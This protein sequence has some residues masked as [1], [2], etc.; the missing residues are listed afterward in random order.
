MRKVHEG[1]YDAIVLAHAGLTRIGLAG[2]ITQVLTEEE[3]LPAPGQGC[4]GLELR[5][6][7]ETLLKFLETIKDASSDAAAR[8]ERAFLSGL[9]G[10]CL[11][12]VGALAT[13]QGGELHMR[14]LLAHPS[15][16][17]M[18]ESREQ[19]PVEQPEYVGSLLAERLL[20]EGGSELLAE[21]DKG[22]PSA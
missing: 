17:T 13:V 2:E 18:V 1:H 3:M 8:A 20:F 16:E 14:A 12:P 22:A 6:S 21:I 11:I 7:D 19:G 15:G 5:E 4:L 10:D 9:G